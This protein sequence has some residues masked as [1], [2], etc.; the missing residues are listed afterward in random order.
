MDVSILRLC[1]VCRGE[2]SVFLLSS[3]EAGDRCVMWTDIPCAH[4]LYCT[5]NL[6]FIHCQGRLSGTAGI[7]YLLLLRLIHFDFFIYP[8]VEL[9]LGFYLD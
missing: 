9:L 6:L 1:C 8:R 3:V 7:N 5:S 2:R 4:S